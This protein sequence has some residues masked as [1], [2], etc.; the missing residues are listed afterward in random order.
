MILISSSSL[1]LRISAGQ[2]RL[3]QEFSKPSQFK[4]AIA[5]GPLKWETRLL[6]FEYWLVTPLIFDAAAL[7]NAADKICF[8]AFFLNCLPSQTKIV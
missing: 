3:D 4:K 6:P 2:M 7:S 5:F 1:S 8:R